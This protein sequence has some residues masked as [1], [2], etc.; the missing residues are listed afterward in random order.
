M[1]KELFFNLTALLWYW[2]FLP[3]RAS[4]VEVST[5]SFISF[6]RKDIYRD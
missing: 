1:Y 4:H 6:F 2:S 5:K 3:V